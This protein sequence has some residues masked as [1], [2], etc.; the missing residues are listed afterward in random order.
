[1]ICGSSGIANW[2]SPRGPMV[3]C[4]RR[5]WLRPAAPNVITS[6]FVLLNVTASPVRPLRVA[7]AE[8]E[9]VISCESLQLFV[10]R[11]GR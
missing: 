3:S 9:G 7:T 8:T 5:G 2:R 4:E 11:S 10:R 6:R 1:M